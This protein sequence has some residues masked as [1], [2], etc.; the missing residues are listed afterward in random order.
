MIKDE[1]DSQFDDY[2]DVNQDN[3]K[4]VLTLN[5]VNYEFMKNYNN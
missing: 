1:C 4:N 5:L 2:R 3:K